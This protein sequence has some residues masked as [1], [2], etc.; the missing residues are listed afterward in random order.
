MDKTLK[1]LE[2]MAAGISPGPVLPPFQVSNT[3]GNNQQST[4]AAP[5]PFKI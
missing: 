2:N 5:N 3:T 4:Q 1:N